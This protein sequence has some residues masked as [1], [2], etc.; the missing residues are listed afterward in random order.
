M[1]LKPGGGLRFCVDYRKLNSITKKDRYPLP[2]ISEFMERISHA[3]IFTKIDIRQGFHRIR[4]DPKQEDLTT[5]RTRYGS[6]KYKVMPFGLTNGPATFQRYM[7]SL[8]LDILDK[9]VT[10]YIDDLLIYSENKAEY[11]MH[12]KLVLQ[13][14]REAGLQTALHKCEFHVKKTKFLGFIISTEGIQ[15]DPAKIAVLKG[16]KEP[17]TKK[18]IQSFLGFCNFYRQFIKDYGKKARPLHYLTKNDMEFVWDP[19]CQEAFD[20][21]KRRLIN[22]PILRH[23]RAEDPARLE[24]D[25]SDGVVAGVLSQQCLDG[26]WRPVAFFSKTMS[27]PERNYEIHDKEMLAIY[28]PWRNGEQN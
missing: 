8:F 3:R 17:T 20:E 7:N 13:R 28:V 18:G 26:N 11:E 2:L 16:W 25:A 22:A 19:A 1:A 23:Y 10:I 6:Y 15:V 4:M 14:L 9:F 27:P 21:L 12:V 5:F 24:T